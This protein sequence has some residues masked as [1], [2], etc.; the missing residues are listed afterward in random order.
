MLGRCADI[1]IGF[2]SSPLP[3][4][5][6]F[7]VHYYCWHGDFFQP[8]LFY[9]GIFLVYCEP[10]PVFFNVLLREIISGGVIIVVRVRSY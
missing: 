10:T 7:I 1:I 5:P 3:T 4:P 2:L 8:C 9:G 6:A